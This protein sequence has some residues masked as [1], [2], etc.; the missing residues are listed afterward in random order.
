MLAASGAYSGGLY[1]IFYMDH[2][3]FYMDYISDIMVI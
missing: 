3:I 2:I 1:I